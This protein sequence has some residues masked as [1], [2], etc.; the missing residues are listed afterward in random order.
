MYDWEREALGVDTLGQISGA[1]KTRLGLTD[2]QHIAVR[3]LPAKLHKPDAP[4][5]R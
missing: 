2:G 1:V 4:H 5:H 3:L